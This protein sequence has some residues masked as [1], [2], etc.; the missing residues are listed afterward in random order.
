MTKRVHG[1][2]QD[3]GECKNRITTKTQ[4]GKHV[5]NICL[6]T[7]R[8]INHHMGTVFLAMTIP[9]WCPLPEVPEEDLSA[10]N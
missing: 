1:I 9:D 4:D 3:C 5:F 2:I 10:Q 7:Q 8:T 6:K